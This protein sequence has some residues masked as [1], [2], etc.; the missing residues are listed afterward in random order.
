MEDLSLLPTVLN[1]IVNSQIELYE[2]AGLTV[3]ANRL[4]RDLIFQIAKK[5]NLE[6]VKLSHNS[7]C[8]DIS[9]K[10][11]K[12]ARSWNVCN[13]RHYTENVPAEILTKMAKI[14]D[15]SKLLILYNCRKPDPILLYQLPVTPTRDDYTYLCVKLAEWD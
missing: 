10:S 15:K 5:N 8:E 11:K 6:I 3:K 1:Q 13:V 9:V 4:R 12:Y 2:Q 14:E 7:T